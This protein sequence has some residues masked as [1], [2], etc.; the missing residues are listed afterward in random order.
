MKILVLMIGPPGSGKTTLRKKLFENQIIICPDELIGYTKNNPWT[1]KAARD[2]WR[3]SDKLLKDTLAKDDDMVVVFDATFVA[4]KKRKK[5]INMALK[6]S[7]V[8][9][10][11]FCDTPISVC[12]E[13][14]NARD[15]NRKVP[16]VAMARMFSNLVAPSLDEGFKLI[17]SQKNSE[18]IIVKGD[19]EV[20][21]IL[22]LSSENWSNIVKGG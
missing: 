3:T 14:N 12:K 19:Q 22:K 2:A 6:A 8:P 9:V 4:P 5:Y 11:V 15:P 13:R 10:A 21:N 20:K 18:N 7:A 16:G 1:A 17:I